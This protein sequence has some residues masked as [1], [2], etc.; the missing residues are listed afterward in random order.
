M[1]LLTHTRTPIL[2]LLI[3]ECMQRIMGKGSGA[4][5]PGVHLLYMLCDHR[6]VTYPLCA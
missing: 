4:R 6:Q 1:Y 5:L 3:K 2:P